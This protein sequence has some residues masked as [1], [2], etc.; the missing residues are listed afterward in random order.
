MLFYSASARSP[1]LRISGVV[2]FIT[3][4]IMTANQNNANI[5]GYLTTNEP[6]KT[7]FA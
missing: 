4:N 3:R 2:Y 6:F 7:Y 5:K 1:A